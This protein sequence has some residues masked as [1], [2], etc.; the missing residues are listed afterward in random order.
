ML[1][2]AEGGTWEPLVLV[3]AHTS[4][5]K[6]LLKQSRLFCLTTQLELLGAVALEDV[7]FAL[8]AVALRD[9]VL[10]AVALRGARG[11]RPSSA[12][13]MRMNWLRSTPGSEVLKEASRHTAAGCVSLE[14]QLRN[15]VYGTVVVLATVWLDTLDAAQRPAASSSDSRAR[16][17][18]MLATSGYQSG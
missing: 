1:N 6:L 3:A 5:I 17:N 16:R 7:A 10:L 11:Q 12:R 13:F 8:G 15:W 14:Q 9:D 4:F 18:G 2:E